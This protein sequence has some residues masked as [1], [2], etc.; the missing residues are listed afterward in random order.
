MSALATAGIFFFRLPSGQF[1][2][3][4]KDTDPAPLYRDAILAAETKANGDIADSEA[5]EDVVSPT[6]GAKFAYEQH[7]QSYLVRNIASLEPGLRLYEEEGFTGVEFPVGGRYIDVLAV[8]SDGDLVVIELKVS[9]GYAQTVGQ[10]LR[11]MA[12]VQKNLAGDKR[13]RGIILASEIGEDL[14]L[15]ASR[16]PDIRLMEYELSFKLKPC[17]TGPCHRSAR[18]AQ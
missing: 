14:R 13:V 6:E 16:V 5:D 11:Y 2:L 4:N 7:L 1:R 10:I 12:W 8:A 9:R 17:R 15:A 3:W 18:C